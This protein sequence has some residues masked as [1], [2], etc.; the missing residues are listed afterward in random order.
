MDI[1]AWQEINATKDRVQA[2][3]DRLSFFFEN[4]GNV[5]QVLAKLEKLEGE[6]RM[7]KARAGKKELVG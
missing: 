3:E 4:S 2:L 6:I 5:A 1:K 7:I